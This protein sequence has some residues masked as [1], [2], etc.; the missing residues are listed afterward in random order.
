MTETRL[1][2]YSKYLDSLERYAKGAKI[3]VE[4]VHG[5]F[6]GGEYHHHTRVLR[7]EPDLPEATEIACFLHELGH[8]FDESSS[9]VGNVRA[10]SKAYVAFY[11]GKATIMQ[12][13]GV[14]RCER[15]AWEY[16]EA[17]AKLLKIP[18]GKWF[19]RHRDYYLK[20]YLEHENS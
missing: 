14:I 15:K 13:I 6:E 1:P 4:Y 9:S 8:A 5:D 12:T 20:G 16:A 18:T 19:A 17:I 3:R 10:L 2:N 7:L 11:K